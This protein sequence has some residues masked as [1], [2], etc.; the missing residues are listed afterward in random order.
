[1]S[2]VARDE[3]QVAGQRGRSDH[4][5]VRWHGEAHPPHLRLKITRRKG[6]FG[7]ELQNP[8]ERQNVT[9]DTVPDQLGGGV[10][11]CSETQFL[12]RHAADESAMWPDLVEAFLDNGQRVSPGRFAYQ[13]GVEEVHCQ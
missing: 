12:Q 7:A 4:Q 9:R 8:Q 10:R 2:G 5:I 1:M 3:R 6:I 11:S 13:I